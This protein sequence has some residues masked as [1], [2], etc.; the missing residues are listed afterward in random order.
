MIEHFVGHWPVSCLQLF[1]LVFLFLYMGHSSAPSTSQFPVV[2]SG[3]FMG[4]TRR[5]E[6]TNCDRINTRPPCK[7]YGR[8]RNSH[9]EPL[10]TVPGTRDSLTETLNGNMEI[11]IISTPSRAKQPY[12]G[13]R[14]ADIIGRN[15]TGLDRQR[16]VG[17]IGLP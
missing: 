2:G 7:I 11:A 17:G 5:Q 6:I 14:D 3:G 4:E 8:T 9:L 10:W 16:R 12:L 13:R 1:I 15:A